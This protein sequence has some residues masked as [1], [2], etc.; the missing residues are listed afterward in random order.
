MHTVPEYLNPV[1]EKQVALYVRDLANGQI[2]NTES[3]TRALVDWCT[4]NGITQYQIFCDQGIYG[5]K[6]S[7]PALNRLMKNI[8]DDQISQVVVFAF[9]T[10]ASSTSHLL[11]AL[12]KLRAKS[13]RFQS[14]TVHRRRSRHSQDEFSKLV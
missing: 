4:R 8:E 7:R 10:F 13:V 9:S 3:Q 6:Q 14:L 1:A 11:R 12:E 2:G 5:A